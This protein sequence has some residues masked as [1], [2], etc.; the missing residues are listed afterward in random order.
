[1]YIYREND[2]VDA[3]TVCR[4]CTVV[5]GLVMTGCPDPMENT[6]GEVAEC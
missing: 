4:H 1:M 2:K 5:G 3:D 6:L